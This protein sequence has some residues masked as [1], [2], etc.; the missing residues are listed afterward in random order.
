[1]NLTDFFRR[2]NTVLGSVVF[3]VTGLA[4]AVN[5]FVAQVAPELPDGWEDNAVRIGAA[6]V[7]V[8]SAAA[9][10]VRR[11]TEVDPGDRSLLP[12]PGRNHVPPT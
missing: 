8:L 12:S 5:E 3:L 9:A 6:V 4:V 10:A 11:L 1:M 7:A 2:L